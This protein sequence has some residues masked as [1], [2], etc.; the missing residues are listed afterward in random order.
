[1][2]TVRDPLRQSGMVCIDHRGLPYLLLP[3]GRACHARPW[4]H[5][6]GHGLLASAP[7]WDEGEY[8]GA[9]PPPHRFEGVAR[10]VRS[11][12]FTMD[13]ARRRDGEWLIM[14][15]GDGQVAGLP[16]SLDVAAFYAGLRD[17][18]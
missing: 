12:F 11:D 4:S 15:L 7:Y 6:A 2:V 8:T 14:E 18:L 1:V 3:S 17:R 16:V 9:P 5:H 10:A 13:V